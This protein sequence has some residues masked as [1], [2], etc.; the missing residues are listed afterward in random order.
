MTTTKQATITAEADGER[1]AAITAE[2]QG[3]TLNVNRVGS[4]SVQVELHV[5]GD[6]LRELAERVVG[7]LVTL[8]AARVGSVSLQIAVSAGGENCWNGCCSPWRRASRRVD[9]R[10]PRPSISLPG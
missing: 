1:I 6:E 3:V 9:R 5:N 10:Q 8:N 7:E 2:G 4:L